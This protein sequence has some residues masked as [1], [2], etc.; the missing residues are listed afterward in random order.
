MR[1]VW[2][3]VALLVASC[4]DAPT[5]VEPVVEP[6]GPMPGWM[7]SVIADASVL[8]VERRGSEEAESIGLW[9]SRDLVVEQHIYDRILRDLETIRKRHGDLDP[10]LVGEFRGYWRPGILS[11][12]LTDEA[13]ERYK[14]GTFTDLD[15][16][17]ERYGLETIIEPYM[18]ESSKNMSL[19]FESRLHPA[20]LVEE[21][22]NIG[23]L[24]WVDHVWTTLAYHPI[25][26]WY[27]HGDLTYLFV[28]DKIE[29]DAFPYRYRYFRTDDEGA[30]EYVG[31]YMPWQEPAPEWWPEAK[32]NHDAFHDSEW[33]RSAE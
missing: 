14:Q 21:Y 3:Y 26:P 29:L 12:G 9:L 18:I 25:Y 24:K 1:I 10:P 15:E 17:N 2:I 19:Y 16:L 22:E 13:F 23:S 32:R 4:S 33:H 11:V 28:Q 27:A 31:T 8:P 5:P 30:I 6:Y 7:R 20:R